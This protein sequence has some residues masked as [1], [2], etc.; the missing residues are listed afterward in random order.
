MHT[1]HTHECDKH[2][3]RDTLHIKQVLLSS[4]LRSNPSRPCGCHGFWVGSTQN[5][6]AP[7][8]PEPCSHHRHTQT[9]TYT[10]THTHIFIAHVTDWQCPQCAKARSNTP[11]HHQNWPSRFQQPGAMS[12]AMGRATM[13]TWFCSTGLKTCAIKAHTQ[14][15]G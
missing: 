10:H 4:A 11:P 13:R 14:T 12:V 5:N 1:N 2:K 15:V 3:R 7:L 9:H 6:T 8:T